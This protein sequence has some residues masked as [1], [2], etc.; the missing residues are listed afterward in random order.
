MLDRWLYRDIAEVFH[1]RN[2]RDL[3]E[4]DLDEA[5]RLFGVLGWIGLE[6]RRFDL[7][8]QQPKRANRI[9]SWVLISGAAAGQIECCCG[10]EAVLFR[11]QPGDHA[12]GF[13]YLEKA[14]PRNSDQHVIDKF[15]V[16][17]F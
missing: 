7:T 16:Q 10:G 1:H 15:F 13:F 9:M 5:L 3:V 11:N 2:A 12:C 14:P 6:A 17:R 8:S 4:Y